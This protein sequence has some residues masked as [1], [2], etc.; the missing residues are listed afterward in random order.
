MQWS[1]YKYK[2]LWGVGGYDW[3][4]SIQE[5]VLHTYIHLDQA[6]V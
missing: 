3:G 5:R 1:F 2:Y 6:R 4:S